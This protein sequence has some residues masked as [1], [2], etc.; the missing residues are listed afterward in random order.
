MRLTID[1]PDDL[2]LDLAI[3]GLHDAAESADIGDATGGAA[4]A[5]VIALERA[6]D[7]VS[8][9]T[10]V[11]ADTLPAAAPASSTDPAVAGDA[12]Q[13]ATMRTTLAHMLSTAIAESCRREAV[14]GTGADRRAHPERA[15]WGRDEHARRSALS[16]KIRGLEAALGNL[17]QAGWATLELARLDEVAP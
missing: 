5:L 8:G 7:D 16:A 13:L 14:D 1:L 4:L 17:Q 9:G 3:A 11:P 6:M 12:A 15:D 10:H 2:D